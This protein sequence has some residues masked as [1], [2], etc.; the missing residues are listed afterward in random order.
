MILTSHYVIKE[1]IQVNF[2]STNTVLHY[3]CPTLTLSHTDVL[4]IQNFIPLNFFYQEIL[5][6][7]SYFYFR[8]YH[9]KQ[10]RNNLRPTMTMSRTV[11]VQHLHF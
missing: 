10:D 6:D 2:V 1:Y 5:P 9:T 7:M 8:D 4:K 11:T 3:N